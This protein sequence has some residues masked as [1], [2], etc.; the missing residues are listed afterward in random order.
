MS[1]PK[2]GLTQFLDFTLKQSGGSRTNHVRKVKNSEYSPATDYWRMLRNE[3]KNI[4]KENANLDALDQLP[5]RVSES[6]RENY[7]NAVRLYKK[8]LK[9]HDVR[10][11]EPSKSIWKFN[12]ELLVRSSPELGLYIDGVPHAIKLYFKGNKQK[13]D[14]RNIQSTLTLLNTSDFESSLPENTVF[15]V[16]N[17]QRNKLYTSKTVNDDL[18]LSLEGEAMNFLHIWNRI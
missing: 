16:L 8:C 15:S 13:V 4:H 11:F 1:E 14:I 9:G 7:K 12:D 18:L 17:I 2:V 5:D 10:W 6:K 3:I